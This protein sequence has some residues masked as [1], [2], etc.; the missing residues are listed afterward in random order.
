M[1]E[2]VEELGVGRGLVGLLEGEI[3]RALWLLV[4]VE[5]DWGD[6]ADTLEL[7]MVV[8]W[9]EEVSLGAR[10]KI[11]I[12]LRNG[13]RGISNIGKESREALLSN[14]PFRELLR[15][16]CSQIPKSRGSDCESQSESEKS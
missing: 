2:A 11:S 13:E 3:D 8:S 14:C 12:G 16:G 1:W 10:F 15:S 4:E 9:Y 6:V 7:V 5:A